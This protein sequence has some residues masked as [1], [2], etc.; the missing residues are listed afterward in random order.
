MLTP[1]DLRRNGQDAL[2]SRSIT[3]IIQA[4]TAAGPTNRPT[5][6]PNPAARCPPPSGPASLAGC[7]RRV[8]SD[9]AAPSAKPRS[10]RRR[11]NIATI[12]WDQRRVAVAPER[13]GRPHAGQRVAICYLSR[14]AGCPVPTDDVCVSET[15][16]AA[17]RS[18]YLA[19]MRWK[20]QRPRPTGGFTS[21]PAGVSKMDLRPTRAPLAD[22]C[23][24]P[25]VRSPRNGADIYRVSLIS[26]G[27]CPDLCRLAVKSTIS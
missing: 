21:P 12:A 6:E 17:I 1:P 15:P 4:P 27:L 16:G 19:A 20:S 2:T 8:C 11:F 14:A 10:I 7:A 18:E 25:Q 3:D 23:R 26:I 22:L 5:R 24:E 13:P 9:R